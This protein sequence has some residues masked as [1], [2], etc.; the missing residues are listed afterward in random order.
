MVAVRVAEH[1][2]VDDIGAVVVLDVPDE[3]LAA[4]LEAGV[5]H[6]VHV[7]A[8]DRVREAGCD[9]VAGAVALTDG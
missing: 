5:D 6:D 3:R 2:E 7:G 1:R 9:G 4:L 8:G